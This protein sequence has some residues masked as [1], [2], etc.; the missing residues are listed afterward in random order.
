MTTNATPKLRDSRLTLEGRVAELTLDRD[1][2][3]NALTGTALIDDIVDAVDWANGSAAVSVLVITGAG[4]AFSAGGN[5]KE[6]QE[7]AGAFAGGVPE[8]EERYRRGIQR[9]PLA[10]HAAEVPVIAAVN[11]PAIGAGCD[12]ACMCDLRIGSTAAMFGETFVNLGIIPGDGGAWF[13]QRLVG[14]Q[15]AAELTFTGRIV[16]AEEACDLGLLLDVVEPAALMSRVREIAC[17]I[18]AKPPQ[19]LRYAKRLMKLAQRMEL[20]D[21][22]DLC[23]AFQGICHNTDDHLEAVA[24]FLEKRPPAYKGR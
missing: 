3:R 24:A 13:L 22:L 23:A 8:V 14:Y 10:M 4:A 1:D 18:A 17:A 12:L 19:A 20:G 16:K 6:M 21:F 15:R 9:I 2:V 5:V 7:R 11:G